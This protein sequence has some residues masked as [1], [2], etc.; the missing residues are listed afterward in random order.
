MGTLENRAPVLFFS[1]L[2]NSVVTVIA[3]CKYT[4]IDYIIHIL[5]V[6]NANKYCK[7]ITIRKTIDCLIATFCIE[8]GF[9]LLHSDKDFDPFAE[10]LNLQVM[11]PEPH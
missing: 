8:N 1:E 9:Q 4:L 7:G 5:E 11:K 3:I 2:T 6:Q 10:H